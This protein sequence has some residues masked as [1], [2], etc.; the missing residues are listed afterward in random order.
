MGGCSSSSKWSC[1]NP[2]RTTPG[3]VV[4]G[5]RCTLRAMGE[6]GDIVRTAQQRDMAAE[7]LGAA[8][9]PVSDKGRADEFQ[10]RGGPLLDGIHRSVPCT[11][12]MAG[13][14]LEQFPACAVVEARGATKEWAADK[15][16]VDLHILLPRARSVCDDRADDRRSPLALPGRASPHR[17]AC[18]STRASTTP[19]V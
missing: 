4:A 13:T 16:I 14:E 15:T 12:P 2:E 17:L 3:A 6:R 7:T 8:V 18:A 11:A 10:E 5:H 1:S 9:Q 19:K